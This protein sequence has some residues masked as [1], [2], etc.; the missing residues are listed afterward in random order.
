MQTLILTIL[1]LGLLVF[2][3]ELGHF[4][5]AKWAGIAVPRFSL[6]LGPR[7]A[8][9]QI[10]ETDYCLSAVPFGGY[11][12]MA[13]MAGEE[14]FES[15][16]GGAIEEEELEGGKPVPPERRFDNK[17]IPWRL[18]VVSA[19]V[20]MNFALGW[21]IYVS[22]AFSE[23][24][25]TV[26][27]TTVD[28]VDSV[29]AMRFD[30]LASLPEGAVIEHVDGV[31]V[32]NWY[33]IERALL[34][35]RGA[36]VALSLASGEVVSVPIG[37]EG[38][39][40][41]LAMGLIPRVIPRISDL[42]PDGPAERAGLQVGDLVVSID[43]VETP[44]FADVSEVVRPRPNRTL[45]VV[46]ERPARGGV[47]RLTIEVQTGAQKSP[48]PEDG[49]FVDTGWIGVTAASG[50]IDLGFGQ[51]LSTGTTATW[52]AGSLI[53]GGLVQLVAGDVS[54]RS[55]GG[56]VAIGQLTGH[57]A[58]QGVASLLGWIA[59]FSINLAVL[60]LLPIPVLDGGHVLF[61]GLE[62]LRGRPLSDR[63]K[64]RMSQVGLAFL[65]LLMAWAFTADILRLVGF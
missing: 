3:H 56:P 42:Q 8:G 46:V 48:R 1:V 12:K 16:E 55:L 9:F 31:E 64:L 27:G 21:V 32:E 20:L 11:V 5:T 10:G 24:R 25:P 39:R 49:K 15:L 4:A 40:R 63:Q 33:E 54:M 14:A 45:P 23:G 26:V 51:A 36:E 7:V 29:A 65:V 44:A 50:R 52:R 61:L 41:A 17:S 18:L 13:G 38:D 6:G 53:I 47:E 58:R 34:E 19:G 57:F 62:G 28:G 22:L 59:L 60:N 30:A 37:G 2:V 35:S 43:G